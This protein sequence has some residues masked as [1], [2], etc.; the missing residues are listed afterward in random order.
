MKLKLTVT[1]DMMQR[2]I[3]DTLVNNFLFFFSKKKWVSEIIN[4]F[5]F[6]II[7]KADYLGWIK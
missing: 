3:T 6:S 7:E 2:V 1:S 5:I 4:T